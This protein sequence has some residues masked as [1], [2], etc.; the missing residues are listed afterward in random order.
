VP[1]KDRTVAR[2]A[3]TGT[4]SLAD[5]ARLDDALQRQGELFASL[6]LW[7]RRTELSVYVSGDELTDLGVGGFADG[8]VDELAAL[9][10]GGGEEAAVAQ[11]ALALLF[12]LAG[13]RA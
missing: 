3:L 13:G 9:A 10:K 1:D 6:R 12:R 5:R 4:L 11:D 7:E 2:L 8:A